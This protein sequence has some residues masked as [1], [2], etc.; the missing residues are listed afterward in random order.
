MTTCIIYDCGLFLWLCCVGIKQFEAKDIKVLQLKVILVQIWETCNCMVR[1]LLN[2]Y[3]PQSLTT[4]TSRTFI[5]C[6]LL[7]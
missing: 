5:N 3:M 6:F 7:T 4:M 1:A 2:Q